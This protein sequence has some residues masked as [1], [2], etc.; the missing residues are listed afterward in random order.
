[1]KY[2]STGFWFFFYFQSGARKLHSDPEY[3]KEEATEAILV[4]WQ[5]IRAEDLAIEWPPKQFKDWSLENNSTEE[6]LALPGYPGVHV[7][8]AGEAIGIVDDKRP[9]Y[10]RPSKAY[11]MTLNSETLGRM[12]KDGM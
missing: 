9:L 7:G 5:Y 6:Y 11:L 4:R 1:M 10:P 2:F 12:W 3:W 8:V